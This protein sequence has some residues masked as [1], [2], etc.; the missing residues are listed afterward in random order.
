L[1]KPVDA[2][3]W[4]FVDETGDPN[5]FD[6]KGN[7]LLGQPGTSPILALGFIETKDP[8]GLRHALAHL[9]AEVRADVYLQSFPSSRSTNLAF[10]AKD[11]R[12]EVRHL[13]F[14]LLR[15]LDFK[16]Q[17]VVARKIERVFRNSFAARPGAFYDHLVMHL[18]SR[19]LHRYQRNHIYFAKRGSRLRQYPLQ[20]A[21]EAGISDFEERWK[22]K[23]QTRTSL[24]AQMPSDEPCLQIVDYV[25]WAVYRAFVAR[26]MRYYKLIEDKV[27]LL[28][29]L[30][31]SEN[32]PRNWYSR[33]NPFEIDKTSPL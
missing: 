17:F 11:D 3:C 10:H 15:N 33:S 26:E 18:F 9:H 4:Y 23:V 8:R 25:N 19:V 13:V 31:D 14:N 21:I 6:A 7:V 24:Q 29:D 1:K 12:P 2:D 5:F 20:K 27:S 30:Y 22:T 16:A 28:V 32:Y